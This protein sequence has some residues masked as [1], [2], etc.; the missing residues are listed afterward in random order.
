[1]TPE[2]RSGSDSLT[3]DTLL[4]TA[5]DETRET[6]RL[7]AAMFGREPTVN[8]QP[9]EFAV[10]RLGVGAN[11]I[12]VTAYTGPGTSVG[13]MGHL[14]Q[15]EIERHAA[16]IAIGSGGDGEPPAWSELDTGADARIQ[17]PSNLIVSFPANTLA[18][19]PLCI[20]INNSRWADHD[21]EI[22]SEVSAKPIAEG[23]LE[24]FRGRLLG[25][26]NPLRGR[27]LE[28]QTRNHEIQ[29]VATK[30]VVADREELVLP[31][32]L[33]KEV[34]IFLAS[35]TSRR[36]LLHSL[37]LSSNR[38]LLIAGPPGV[39]KTHLA[40]VLATELAGRYTTILA[41]ANAVRHAIADLYAAGDTFGPL[42]VVLDDI[43][44]VLGHREGLG[45]DGPLAN[46]LAALDGVRSRQ[47]I[48]TVA[49]TNDPSSLDPAA[50]RANRFDTV[51]TL[52]LPDAGSRERIL[53]KHLE[54]LGLSID[55]PV[56]A[57]LLEAA[58]GA[59]V[60]EVIRRTIL[61]HGASFTLDDILDVAE[62]GRW[63]TAINRGRYLAPPPASSRRRPQPTARLMNG[64]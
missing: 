54:Q 48:L 43:D 38:G 45:N 30:N 41:E 56:V 23:V 42:L 46:F 27:V 22:L 15:R 58:S 53:R 40:R 51:I 55:F 16:R 49:T 26:D 4:A 24:Q 28:P 52:P 29:L 14:L 32:A 21:F 9:L 20:R 19:V 6:L 61:E 64:D 34:D 37:G 60:K 17:V 8:L 44:L 39:G 47:D 31:A 2:K 11:Q 62:S 59:D 7:L 18:E 3:I 10:R 25:P 13:I 63:K 1:M 33:W 57:E 12:A 36:E 35:A 5:S 50:Q